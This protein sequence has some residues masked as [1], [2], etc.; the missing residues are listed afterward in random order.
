MR[1]PLRIGD[2]EV[3]GR[4]LA[5]PMTG[6][7]DLPFRRAASRLGA[8][9]VATE[10]VACETFVKGR[11]D[12]VR[13]AAVGDGLPLTVIQLVGREARW[14]ARAAEIAEEAGADIIDLNMGCPAKEVTGGLS[15]SALMRDL[16]H[17]ER[18]IDAAVG[19]TSRPVTLKIRLGWDDASRNAPE[20]A[21]RAERAGIKAITV[22]G[23]TRQQFYKGEADW[24]AVR[25]VKAATSLPV[26]V[27]GDVVDA[28][29]AREAL[30]Q[31]GADAVMIGRGA[32][33]RPWLPAAIDAALAGGGN[34]IEPCVSER[35]AIVLEH[36]ADSLRFYGEALGLK[37]FRKHLGWYVEQAP[38]PASPDARRAARS[39]LCRLDSAVEVERGLAALWLEGLGS[40]IT[41]EPKHTGWRNAESA[42]E[43]VGAAVVTH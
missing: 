7:S 31:S 20:L 30:A 14:I 36:F 6:V 25:E 3:N 13:R 12:V 27:N 10:M 22:H 1:E 2:V 41:A 35:H 40:G 18:L 29:S 4:V 42:E 19:A 9:Y 37:I 28:A 16:E 39:R 26:I 15:G 32:Y 43:C 34:A 33:G 23:R 8:A 24:R 5:A 17:A 21:A 11:P 38:C